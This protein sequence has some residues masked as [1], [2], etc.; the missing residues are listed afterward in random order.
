MGVWF[1]IDNPKTFIEIKANQ[2]REVI[3]EIDSEL[4]GTIYWNDSL[5]FEMKLNKV[6][7]VIGRGGNSKIGKTYTFKIINVSTDTL[8]MNANKTALTFSR[9]L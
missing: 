7:G 2:Y 3:G 5:T 1:C 4:R 6:E 9:T 8:R